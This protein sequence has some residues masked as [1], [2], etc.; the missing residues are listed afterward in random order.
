MPAFQFGLTA[1]LVC[2]ERS[3]INSSAAGIFGIDTVST[4]P[5]ARDIQIEFGVDFLGGR[6][7]GA[8]RRAPRTWPAHLRG[9]GFRSSLQYLLLSHMPTS[10]EI[11][12][13]GWTSCS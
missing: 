2:E 1:L 12:D 8:S 9:S 10:E 3:R 5:P 7:L 6:P 11:E 13:F 4:V